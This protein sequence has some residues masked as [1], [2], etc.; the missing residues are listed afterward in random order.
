MDEKIRAVLEN[1]QLMESILAALRSAGGGEAAENA[2][3]NAPINAPTNEVARQAAVPDLPALGTVPAP[4]GYSQGGDRGL[5]LLAALKP[6][7]KESRRKK[8]DM[9]KG[10]LSV[11]ALYKNTKNI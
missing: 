7:L 3:I 11:A 10:V 4:Y 2:P 6:F 9:A 1:P 8:L 5:A